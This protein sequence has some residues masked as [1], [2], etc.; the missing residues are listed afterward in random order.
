MAV[1]VVV[2]ALG[3]PLSA[4][5]AAQIASWTPWATM[6]TVAQNPPAL[7]IGT[8]SRWAVPDIDGDRVVYSE[9]RED[10][11]G[12]GPGT[13]AGDFNIHMLDIKTNA[14]IP[15]S[16]AAGDQVFPR[17]SGDWVVY[18]ETIGSASE[19]KAFRIS[20]GATVD[21]TGSRPGSQLFPDVSDSKVVYQDNATGEVRMF[22]LPSGPDILVQA[23]ARQ[24]SVSG[25]RVA[26]VTSDAPDIKVKDLTTG[27]VTPVT[28]D[29]AASDESSP[30]IDGDRI[31]FVKG[32]GSI[33][34]H[35]LSTGVTKTAATASAT[36]AHLFP[37]IS[38]TRA[39][40][41][42]ADSGASLI[43]IRAYDFMTDKSVTLASAAPVHLGNPAISGNR[44]VFV[45]STAPSIYM[46]GQ[47]ELAAIAAP[48]VSLSTPSGVAYGAKPVLG[49][50]LIENETPLGNRPL[51][52]LRSTNGGHTW[53]TVGSTTTKAD[54]SFSYTATAIYSKA[55]Y[56]VHFNGATASAGIGTKL[57]HFSAQSDAA[58]VTPAASLGKPAGYPS[59][60][61]RTKTYTVY[62]SLKPKQ[63]ASAASAKAVVIKCYK[64]NGKKY[65]LSKTVNAKVFNYSTYSRYEGK[66]KLT[67]GTWRMRAYFK[68]SPT[69]GAKYSSYKKV[70]VK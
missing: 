67:K 25:N 42:T 38:G 24:P 36:I 62:G 22:T 15:V 18:Q 49:G 6:K 46:F 51:D 31:V 56:R 65:K 60:G 57:E 64:W 33:I 20:T 4:Y 66:V 3:V 27:V 70:K 26:F 10:A 5:A 29:G 40:W 54:G 23:A 35:T 16:T 21:V 58:V 34:A 44:A 30:R 52:V 61:K 41:M 17:I 50:K 43:T 7:L 19:V 39:V 11:D 45:S 8:G 48:T 1:L 47:I 14:R 13:A 55:W 37:D 28:T 53:T 68:G 9:Q 2:L 63:A 59:T 69:N 12:T 32:D